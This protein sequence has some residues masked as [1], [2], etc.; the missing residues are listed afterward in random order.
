MPGA[1]RTKRPAHATLRT[2]QARPRIVDAGRAPRWWGNGEGRETKGQGRVG[3]AAA[4]CLPPESRAAGGL[5]R[6]CHCTARL[7]ESVSSKL[8]VSSHF[9]AHP[10]VPCVYGPKV[11]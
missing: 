3:A 5:L 7:P 8:S 1:S 10:A 9:S 4:S 2:P 11:E 6:G